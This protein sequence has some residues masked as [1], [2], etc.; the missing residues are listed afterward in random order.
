MAITSTEALPNTGFDFLHQDVAFPYW[1][2][3]SEVWG[4]NLVLLDGGRMLV[5]GVA[6]FNTWDEATET[7]IG[8]SL[9]LGGWSFSEATGELAPTTQRSYHFPD[10]WGPTP[11]TDPVSGN[12]RYYFLQDDFDARHGAHA[13]DAENVIIIHTDNEGRLVA[14]LVN[15]PVGGS[16][17]LVDDLVIDDDDAS[18]GWSEWGFSCVPRANPADGLVLVS[19]NDPN[20]DDGDAHLGIWLVWVQGGALVHSSQDL[21]C[22]TTGRDS[23]S[24]TCDHF[25]GTEHLFLGYGRSVTD[26]PMNAG[27]AALRFENGTGFVPPEGGTVVGGAEVSVVDTPPVGSSAPVNFE[28]VGYGESSL[29]LIGD[30]SVAGAIVVNGDHGDPLGNDPL[31]GYRAT[32][33]GGASGDFTFDESR[34]LTEAEHGWGNVPMQVRRLPGRN[35]AVMF[36]KH[37]RDT[38]TATDTLVVGKVDSSGFVFDRV[39]DPYAESQ[40]MYFDIAAK[41]TEPGVES[42]KMVVG[43]AG[44]M[45]SG[46]L[47]FYMATIDTKEKAPPP[48]VASA[49]RRGQRAVFA[50]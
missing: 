7:N 1:D 4:N 38:N 17:T 20:P 47:G 45:S 24:A 11:V 29:A 3:G 50:R 14:L 46:T 32:Y 41:I 12:D 36:G 30:A 22:S 9:I 48:P 25:G 44:G 33:G 42:S 21:T 6:S 37:P 49:K 43:H 5:Y 39:S 28:G 18:F 27:V 40:W 34:W 31:F 8:R 26:S 23:Y 10:W 13:V 35:Y 15:W 16:P 19:V 2:D